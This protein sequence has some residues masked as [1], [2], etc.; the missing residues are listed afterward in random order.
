MSVSELKFKHPFTCIVAGITGSGKTHWT[1]QL[2][3]N[4][5][6]L[7]KINK[8]RLKVLWCFGEDQSLYKIPLRN[9]DIV[10]L[11]G[12]PSIEIIKNTNPDIIVI[13]DL[14]N[15]LKNDENIK[16]LF[17]KGSHHMN[18]SVIYITQNIFA[19]DKSMRTIS[20]NS[21]YIV[22]MKGIRLTQQITILGNQI[23]PGKSKKFMNIFKEATS[24]P[25]SYLLLDLHPASDDRF[26]IRNRIFRCELDKSLASKFESVP[27]YYSLE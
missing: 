20:L 17:I 26:R 3:D 1:R 22:I 21:Q 9:V 25:F 23:F 27:I 16:S 11:K 10:Y 19:Q 15:D 13:D 2:L 12:I 7:I 5:K 18:I 4:Y 24:K 8:T 6:Y 14:M